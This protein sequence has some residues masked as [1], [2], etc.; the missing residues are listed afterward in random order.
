[1]SAINQLVKGKSFGTILHNM[2]RATFLKKKSYCGIMTT[3]QLGF[4]SRESLFIWIA[5]HGDCG[6]VS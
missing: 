6:L 2:K 5:W 1:M 3:P 4:Y